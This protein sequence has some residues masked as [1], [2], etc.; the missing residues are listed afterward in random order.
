MAQTFLLFDEITNK[1]T[2]IDTTEHNCQDYDPE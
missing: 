1:K 2:E